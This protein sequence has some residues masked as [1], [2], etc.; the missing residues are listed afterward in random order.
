MPKSSFMN[1]DRYQWF[2]LFSS[3]LYVFT[4]VPHILQGCSSGCDVPGC[5]SGSYFAFIDSNMYSDLFICSYSSLSWVN[6][7]YTFPV[8]NIMSC[9]F[10]TFNN[11]RVSQYLFPCRYI[12]GSPLYLAKQGQI[13]LMWPNSCR[14]TY[15]SAP[16]LPHCTSKCT[17]EPIQKG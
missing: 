17:R 4:D 3:C 7:T 13:A 6:C 12:L 5:S 1:P 9:R 15:E 11:N 10:S 16:L 14:F 8:S 2:Y